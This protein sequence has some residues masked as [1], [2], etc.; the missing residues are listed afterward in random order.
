MCA[1]ANQLENGPPPRIVRARQQQRTPGADTPARANY[2]A[3]TIGVASGSGKQTRTPPKPPCSGPAV[4]VRQRKTPR[5][6]R[7]D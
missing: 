2:L 7:D 6:G 3:R 1:H 4:R 5:H